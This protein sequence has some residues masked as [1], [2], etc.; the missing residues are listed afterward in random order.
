[1]PIYIDESDSDVMT[2]HKKN[3]LERYGMSSKSSFV[4]KISDV[5]NVSNL[6][7]YGVR[8]IFELII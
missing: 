2:V 1:M 8:I 5:Y 4:Q 7:E 3:T 6:Y